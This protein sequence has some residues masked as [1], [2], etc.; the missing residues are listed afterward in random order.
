MKNNK[1]FLGT[2]FG[3]LFILVVTACQ[4]PENS[5]AESSKSNSNKQNSNQ[6]Y[7]IEVGELLLSDIQ[8]VIQKYSNYNSLSFSDIKSIRLELSNYRK[9]NFGSIPDVTRKECYDFLVTHGSSPAE[10]EQILENLDN[11]GNSI[12][13]YNVREPQHAAYLYAEKQ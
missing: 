10:T 13:F 2:L 3:I 1:F 7:Y 12:V 9:Y 5:A 11:R 6:L 4:Q 8:A